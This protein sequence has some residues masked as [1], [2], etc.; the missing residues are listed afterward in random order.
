MW[1]ADA[2][3][4][5]ICPRIGQTKPLYWGLWQQIVNALLIYSN[6]SWA[7]FPGV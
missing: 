2:V 4:Y 7:N 1:H 6:R 5:A 3:L